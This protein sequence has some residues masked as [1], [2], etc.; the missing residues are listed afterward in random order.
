MP[1]GG[2]ALSDHAFSQA[3]S[4]PACIILERLS[5]TSPSSPAP[6]S[7][8]VEVKRFIFASFDPQA[9]SPSLM[10]CLSMALFAKPVNDMLGSHLETSNRFTAFT[11]TMTIN[12]NVS[13]NVMPG[14]LWLRAIEAA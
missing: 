13:S 5:S 8:S 6:Y 12:W 14:M 11:I 1:S 2:R 4:L 7:P 9:G 3:M 10:S